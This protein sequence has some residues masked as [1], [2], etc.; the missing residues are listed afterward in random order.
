MEQVVNKKAYELSKTGEIIQ[1]I[2]IILGALLVPAVVP[3]LL[4]VIFGKTSW[5]ASHSQIIVGSIVNTA[6]IMTGINMKGWRKILLVATL[7]SLSA[8]GSGYIFG[9]LTKV[10][11]FMVPG[12]WLGNFAL[13]MLMKYLY[14]NKNINYAVSAIISIVVKVA[15]IFGVLKIW[16]AFSVLPNQG[17][18]ANTLRNTMGLTQAITATIGAIISILIIKIGFTKKSK[19]TEA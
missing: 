9:S 18:V 15:I 12:I 3:Q 14:V 6:L 10:T 8:I 5:I 2:L 13:I 7:P 16:M 11:I 1:T 4:Q 19:I 17:T